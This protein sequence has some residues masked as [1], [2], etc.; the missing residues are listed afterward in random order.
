MIYALAADAVVVIHLL[1]ILLAVFGGLL[2]IWRR[3]MVFLHLPALIWA[4]WIVATHGICPLTPLENS[5]RELAGEVGYRGGFI[6]HYLIPL[7]YPP[8]LTPAGQS[9]LAAILSALNLLV[10]GF[11]WTQWRHPR[12]A[13]SGRKVPNSQIR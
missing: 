2:V 4:V 7:I 5:L 9:A 10:Y 12:A 3:A 11:A 1:F 6:A 8:G 13:I